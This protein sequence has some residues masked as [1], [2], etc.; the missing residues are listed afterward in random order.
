MGTGAPPEKAGVRRPHLRR[1]RQAKSF[2]R[3]VCLTIR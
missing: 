1:L 2:S 3:I